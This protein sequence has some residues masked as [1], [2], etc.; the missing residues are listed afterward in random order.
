MTQQLAPMSLMADKVEEDSIIVRITFPEKQLNSTLKLKVNVCVS[1]ILERILKR[2]FNI[3]I[4]LNDYKLVTPNGIIMDHMFTLMEYHLPQNCVLE[5]KKMDQSIVEQQEAQQQTQKQQHKFFDVPLKDLMNEQFRYKK[6]LKIPTFIHDAIK[7]ILRNGLNH[8]GIFSNCGT[9]ENI[10]ALRDSLNRGDTIDFEKQK[11]AI[12]DVC[13]LIKMF[14]R[15]LPDCLL[16]SD[17]CDAFNAV[18]KMG[19]IQTSEVKS[20]QIAR[21][22]ALLTLLPQ[23]QLDLMYSIL[24]LLMNILLN[25]KVNDATIDELANQF[26]VAFLWKVG[27]YPKL[28][29]QFFLELQE[30]RKRMC[31]F[32]IEEFYALFEEFEQKVFDQAD[33]DDTPAAA[34]QAAPNGYVPSRLSLTLEEI[35]QNLEATSRRERRKKR[36]NWGVF[37]RRI[38]LPSPSICIASVEI[39]AE[40]PNNNQSAVKQH[41]WS[42]D[43]D[44]FIRIWD[45]ENFKIVDQI[46]WNVSNQINARPS[47]LNC[48]I[49]VHNQAVWTG[50][51]EYIKVFNPR[52]FRLEREITALKDGTPAG[53]IEFRLIQ[54]ELWSASRSRLAQWDT[55]KFECK[56]MISIGFL[57]N[58]ICFLGDE[59]GNMWIGLEGGLVVYD[60]K[61]GLLVADLSDKIARNQSV[62]AIA[63]LPED[64]EL[65]TCSSEGSIV[66]WNAKTRDITKKLNVAQ[67]TNFSLLSFENTVW[68]SAG[69]QV[70]IWDIQTYACVSQMKGYHSEQ[71][72]CM[73]TTANAHTR[74]L[75][76][77]KQYVWTASKDSSICV[78]L[79]NPRNLINPRKSLKPVTAADP[80][81]EHAVPLFQSPSPAPAQQAPPQPAV[82]VKKLNLMN[83]NKPEDTIL[84]EMWTSLL[85]HMER[86]NR[87]KVNWLVE[88]REDN[89]LGQALK[90]FGSLVTYTDNLKAV[91]V[92]E[93]FIG[94]IS[95]LSARKI[96]ASE[97]V[98]TY[99]VRCSLSK[100]FSFVLEFVSS[101]NATTALLIKSNQRGFLLVNEDQSEKLF[102]TMQSL[103]QSRSLV[104][105]KPFLLPMS[106]FLD[107]SA[108]EAE[109]LLKGEPKGTFLIR[110]SSK[111]GSFAVSFVD[112]DGSI[113]K[114]IISKTS[115]GTG[116]QLGGQQRVFLTIT[117]LVRECQ[118]AGVFSKPYELKGLY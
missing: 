68:S 107:V 54:G 18:I 23:Y 95:A 10:F 75:S 67:S 34:Q 55:Q 28:D 15:H 20:V 90:Q 31:K 25:S 6:N 116:Y 94:F 106:W 117:D 71:I 69:P 108:E 14:L 48:I 77:R 103:I 84:N 52:T 105:T 88:D 72:T 58:I 40:T 104:L 78:W 93:Y 2:N 101:A 59:H 46:G 73:A 97:S 81:T 30:Q 9:P 33:Q 11:L 100:P 43:S 85:L 29:T 64:D 16:T 26:G 38:V 109:S 47:K 98:G 60:K 13:E 42:A 74:A 44:G 62:N 91:A 4:N 87:D 66:V 50:F 36:T 19:K 114:T 51:G 53:T 65:W 8:K 12:Q 37:Y 115:N 61:T 70:L 82:P 24:T 17:L 56:A 79:V 83:N 86:G 57:Q 1:T 63:Y 21:V 96:L 45:A 118:F 76:E 99:F 32:F 39:P 92:S 7:Y 89:P 22:K 110:L 80:S 35:E 111:L 5:L 102:P 41:I 112:S 3:S 49:N 113:K 27:G